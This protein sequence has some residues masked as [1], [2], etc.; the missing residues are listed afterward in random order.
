MFARDRPVPP[1]AASRRL[2][3]LLALT[4]VAIVVVEALNLLAT[5]EPG[6]SLL[7]RTIWALLR[8]V[9]FLFLMRA[10]RYGRAAARPFGLILAITTVFAVARLTEPREGSLVPNTAVLV[11]F[12]VLAVLCGA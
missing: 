9:G 12:A 1:T 5:P 7:V 3:W 2:R 10:V 11:G 4:A 6:F 8:V